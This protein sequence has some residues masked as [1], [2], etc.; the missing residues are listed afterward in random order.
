MDVNIINP[1]LDAFAEILPQIGF[2]TVEKK[3]VS[4]VESTVEY[5]GVLVNIALLGAIKGVVLIGMDMESAK[6]FAS[7]MMMGMEVSTL[8]PLAQS[9]LS[10]MGNMVVAN[11]CTHFNKI[12][13]N[14]LEISPPTLLI[15]E[16]GTATLPVPKAIMLCFTVDDINVDVYVGI[17]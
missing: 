12:G 8:D 6:V 5:D 14:G 7:K 11:S 9:A 2:S 3:S 15:S 1:I 13:I 4:L 17:V 16:E 10:E